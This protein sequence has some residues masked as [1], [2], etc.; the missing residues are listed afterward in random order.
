MQQPRLAWQSC[1]CVVPLYDVLIAVF[2][3]P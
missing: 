1:V 2:I 3:S